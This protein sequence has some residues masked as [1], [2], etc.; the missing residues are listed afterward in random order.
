M[1]NLEDL[2]PDRVADAVAR[3]VVDAVAAGW[4]IESIVAR[5]LTAAERDLGL[6]PNGVIERS[7]PTGAPASIPA[8]SPASVPSPRPA[9]PPPP[10]ARRFNGGSARTVVT[11]DDVRVAVAAGQREIRVGTGAI[12]TALARD[13]AQDAGIR[14]VEA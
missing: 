7:R 13:A 14:L 5:A 4:D 2:A 10:I 9:P 3:A 12:V 11:E 6:S 8:P 1:A